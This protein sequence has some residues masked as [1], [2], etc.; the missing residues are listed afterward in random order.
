MSVFPEYRPSAETFREHVDRTRWLGLVPLFLSLMLMFAAPADPG[1][2]LW[3]AF[4]TVLGLHLLL[5]GGIRLARESSRPS[6]RAA[7][8]W[9]PLLLF[10]VQTGFAIVT[11]VLIWQ[12]LLDLGHY[13]SPAEEVVLYTLLASFPAHRLI[14]VRAPDEEAGRRRLRWELFFR[15]LTRGLTAILLSLLLTDLLR[16]PAGK[17]GQ[18]GI[19]LAIALWVTTILFVL[20]CV[21]FFIERAL[22]VSGPVQSIRSETA[23]PGGS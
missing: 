7:D 4:G 19:V 13:S 12:T 11:A 16:D 1:P 23:P 10:A 2:G 21:T 3:S 9:F 6:A 18:G 14:R 15:Y 17:I 8:R 5:G 22:G 20:G